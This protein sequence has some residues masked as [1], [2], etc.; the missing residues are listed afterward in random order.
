MNRVGRVVCLV[1]A[2]TACAVIVARAWL[3]TPALWPPA[4]NAVFDWLV[5]A[6]G[7]HSQDDVAWV[8][9]FVFWVL[10]LVVVATVWASSLLLRRYPDSRRRCHP[11]KHSTG[12]QNVWM[13]Y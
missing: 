5:H 1:L 10:A 4:P 8:A 9:F 13:H 3:G 11:T 12:V 7:L 6:F 2:L